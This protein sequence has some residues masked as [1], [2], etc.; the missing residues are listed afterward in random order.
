MV[1]YVVAPTRKVTGPVLAGGR[2]VFA[3]VGEGTFA[4]VGVAFVPPPVEPFCPQPVSCAAIMITP[5]MR[6]NRCIRIMMILLSPRPWTSSVETCTALCKFPKVMRSTG[7]DALLHFP[8]QS[9]VQRDSLFM[10]VDVFTIYD[11][12]AAQTMYCEAAD[13]ISETAS[14]IKHY[15]E[16][17]EL[18]A[19][20]SQLET[21]QDTEEMIFDDTHGDPHFH[22]V[23]RLIG[24]KPYSSG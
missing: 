9:E 19:W 5:A 10:Y 1:W 13:T 8:A 11:P 24:R 4:G 7:N 2:G 21:L 16:E 14:F 20:F 12:G 22:G 6:N 3:T 18:A 15:F 17:G 23:A